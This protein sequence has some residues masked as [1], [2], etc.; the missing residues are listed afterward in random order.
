MNMIP[1][2]GAIVFA[3]ICRFI[4]SFFFFII[5]ICIRAPPLFLDFLKISRNGGETMY[6]DQK[7][8]GKRI[9][10]M[11]NSIGLTQ[12]QLAEKLNIAT[13]TLGNIERGSKG[14]SI[15]LAVEFCVV[16][17]VSLDYLILGERNKYLSMKE[18]IHRV[19]ALLTEMLKRL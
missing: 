15:D 19:I 13:S 2:Q 6:Y 3:Y 14:I 8:C 11:R 16:L 17:D 4:R 1:T 10:N 9:Q 5:H 7:K 18:I 12:D